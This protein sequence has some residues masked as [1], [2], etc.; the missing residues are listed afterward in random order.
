MRAFKQQN[1][2]GPV[3]GPPKRMSDFE[4]ESLLRQRP[5]GP[6]FTFRCPACGNRLRAELEAA[7]RLG[8]C[9]VCE[10]CFPVPPQS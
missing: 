6:K 3:A 5:L 8:Q 10:T 7:G 9:P 2:G 4:L 1:T